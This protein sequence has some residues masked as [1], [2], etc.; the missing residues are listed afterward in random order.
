MP[1]LPA[2]LT[3]REARASVHALE[4]TLGEGSGAVAIDASAL[5]S[6][7]SAAIA[8]LLELRR[9]AQAAGRTL[10]VSGAPD[11]MIDLAGLYGVAELLGLPVMTNHHST[12]A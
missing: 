2:T 12:R 4:S 9:Q 1:A 7:D 3:M 11:S 10:Q 6:F 8:A 5:K